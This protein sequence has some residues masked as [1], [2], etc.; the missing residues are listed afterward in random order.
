VPV[1]WYVKVLPDP[2]AVENL[3]RQIKASGKAFAVFEVAKLF[4]AAPDRY[5]LNFHF[6]KPKPRLPKAGDKG[7]EQKP[8][9]PARPLP[10][11]KFTQLIQCTIDGALF[12]TREEAVRHCRENGVLESLFTAETVEVEAPKGSFTQVGVCGFSGAVFGPPNH[13]S[14]QVAIAKLHREKFA[15]MPLDRYK[16]RIKIEKDEAKVKEWQDAQGKQ[17]HYTPTRVAEGETPAV[18]KSLAERDAYFLKHHADEVLVTVPN[19]T[20]SG[21]V[22]PHQLSP[23]LAI[24]HRMEM[25]RQRKFPIHLVQEVCRDMEN[26]GL[27]FFKR[28]KTTTF[29]CKNRPH[30]IDEQ[31]V[32]SERVRGIVELVRSNPGIIYTKLVSVLAPRPEK[33]KA[34][35]PAP[36]PVPVAA[37]GEATET[38]EAAPAP[39]AATPPPAPEVQLSTAEVAIMQDLKWLVQEG[40]ITE[41]SKGELHILGQKHHTRERQSVVDM[42][43]EEVAE[44]EAAAE[45]AEAQAEEPTQAVESTSEPVTAEAPASAEESVVAEE[46]VANGSDSVETESAPADEVTQNT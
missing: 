35:A 6:K 1:G 45:Q 42:V 37:E 29:V 20:V 4:L 40:Y 15:N 41:F 27:R 13:H 28:N 32:L 19:A 31:I 23:G 16:S 10:E 3:A 36:T 33:E 25:E 34:P 46:E 21:A 43:T 8:A 24:V 11:P 18:L 2:R 30:F 14:Y 26:Q 12:F 38:T 7:G 44:A 22:K 17:V 5:L 39:A 9:P